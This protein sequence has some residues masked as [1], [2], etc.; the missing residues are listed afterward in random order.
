MSAELDA[1]ALVMSATPLTTLDLLDLNL[2]ELRAL[3]DLAVE[4]AQAAERR[5]IAFRDAYKRLHRF[6]MLEE[7][8][9][10]LGPALQR[11]RAARH[12]LGDY[13]AANLAVLEEHAVAHPEVFRP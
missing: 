4:Q 9:A 6:G 5:A 10:S 2:A 11:F 8:D 12:L 7:G 3:S 1:L 13:A